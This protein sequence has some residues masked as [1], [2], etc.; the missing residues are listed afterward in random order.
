MLKLLGLC[1][2]VFGL[3]TP[4]LALDAPELTSSV[5]R[6]NGK[7]FK[8]VVAGTQTIYLPSLGLPVASSL[9]EALC[10]KTLTPSDE[11]L[12]ISKPGP[13]DA[14]IKAEANGILTAMSDCAKAKDTVQPAATITCD[15]SPDV[16]Q[17]TGKDGQRTLSSGGGASPGFRCRK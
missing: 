4:A 1:L 14:E 5:V 3:A 13:A 8:K 17:E 9:V 15:S 12:E 6:I 7:R 11:V 16:P 10:P 2:V